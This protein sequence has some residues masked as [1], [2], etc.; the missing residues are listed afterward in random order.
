VFENPFPLGANV[1]KF[2][3]FPG[4]GPNNKFSGSS[5]KVTLETVGHQ[6]ITCLGSTNAGEYTGE[7]TATATLTLTGLQTSDG[8][9]VPEQRRRGRAKI[10]TS[11]LSGELGFIQ[12]FY[13]GEETL[14][15]SVGLDLKHSP[16]LLTAH[17][18]AA[19]VAVSGSVIVPLTVDK[20]AQSF[21]AKFVAPGGKQVPE[22]FEEG[23]TDVLTSNLG[24]S[25]EQTGLTASEKLVNQEPIEIKAANRM[26]A[27]GRVS[28]RDRAT[29][30]GGQ[31]APTHPSFQ[32]WTRTARGAG[33]T[34]PR[35]RVDRAAGRVDR[36]EDVDRA[37]D[38]QPDR[39]QRGRPTGRPSLSWPLAS[40]ASCPS[41]RRRWLLVSE[42]YR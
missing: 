30:R 7:K 42:T 16:T 35:G 11:P 26:T 41:A 10:V 8:R 31:P 18:G 17:C 40:A 34:G 28:A 27:A 5:L 39:Q 25:T 22:A 36:L 4:P 12:D 24:G 6:A 15:V 3:W 33:W 2:E 38:D 9:N 37:R 21:T 20:M 14:K 13:E 1:G 32:R 23:P 19:E 29:M